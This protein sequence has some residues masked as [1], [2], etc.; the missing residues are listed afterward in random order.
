[1][2]NLLEQSVYYNY[3]VNRSLSTLYFGHFEV[4]STSWSAFTAMKDNY[5]DVPDWIRLLTYS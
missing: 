1:M 4:F 2:Q 5:M 3:T